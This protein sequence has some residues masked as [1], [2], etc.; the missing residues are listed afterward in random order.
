MKLMMVRHGETE[1]NVKN[2]MQ[3]HLPGKLTKKGISQAKKLAKRLKEERFDIIYSSDLQRAR[4]TC[5]EI[6]RYHPK[7][8][9]RYVKDIRE[10]NFG[11]WEGRTFDEI[12]AHLER[13]GIA[14]SDWKPY[15]GESSDQKTE[16]VRIFFNKMLQDH[17]GDSVLWVT[18]GGVIHSV[19]YH[20]LGLSHE[21]KETSQITNTAV[22]M[23]EVDGNGKHKVH[24][25]N[26]VEHLDI[27]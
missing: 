18:H 22:S 21:N 8:E 11:V 20:I 23:I 9:A 7:T 27:A 13:R 15:K 10:K 16:R 4:D 1:E 12:E 2:I 25:V 6:K 14:W 26:S 19:L 5:Q 24:F 17:T 3:G